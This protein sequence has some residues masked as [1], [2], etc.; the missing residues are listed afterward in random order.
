MK[1]KYSRFLVLSQI[2]IDVPFTSTSRS[3]CYFP[4]IHTTLT[5]FFGLFCKPILDRNWRFKLKTER[6]ITNERIS[7]PILSPRKRRVLIKKKNTSRSV[8]NSNFYI[9]SHYNSK[10]ILY[11]V[12]LYVCVI[13]F[14]T[15]R[16]RRCLFLFLS[17]K[18]NKAFY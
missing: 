16:E 8:T 6:S 14:C 1:K 5:F 2:N 7:F 18:F 12:S 4:P 9:S 3:Y 10:Y 13:F 15:L 11:H 17:Y